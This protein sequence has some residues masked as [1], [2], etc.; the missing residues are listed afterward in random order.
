MSERDG[1]RQAA[2]KVLDRD[3]VDGV[4][5]SSFYEAGSRPVARAAEPKRVNDKPTHY[6]VI[7]ISMYTA[8]LKRLD[9]MVD[10]LKSRGLTKA[11][12]SALIRYALGEVDL[13][14]VPKG[15]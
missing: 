11:N 10:T 4:L 9:T 2:A 6:K 7:C 12:R 8:D 13:E 1:F 3:E 5:S 15:L 14:T